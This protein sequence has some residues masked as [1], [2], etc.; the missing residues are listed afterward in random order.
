[1]QAN[2]V[3]QLQ[4][5]IEGLMEANDLQMPLGD[6]FK[7]VKPATVN[8]GW[9]WVNG[10][11]QPF[12]QHTFFLQPR[13]EGRL[14]I[15][16]A[17]LFYKGR[18]YTGNSLTILVLPPKAANADNTTQV[19]LVK[20]LALGENAQQKIRENLF[21]E[22]VIDKQEVTVGEPLMASFQLHTRLLSDAKI[23]RRPSFNGF[24]VVDMEA[25]ET[26]KF[27][28]TQH[29]GK[30]YNT[31]VIRKVQ[32]FPLLPGTLE[33]EPLEVMNTVRFYRSRHQI[34]NKSRAPSQWMENVQAQMEA[35]A[36]FE[37]ETYTT[38][39]QTLPLKV[40]VKPLP[41]DQ[42]PAD[43]EGAVGQFNIEAKLLP[44]TISL[45]ETA[46]LRITISGS[47]NFPLLAPP[48]LAL[49]SGLEA[50]APKVSEQLQ[51][52][53][54]PLSGW[55]QFDYPV[56]AHKAGVHNLPSLRFSYYDMQARRYKT[57]VTQPLQL[58][59]TPPVKTKEADTPSTTLPAA[60][61]WLIMLAVLMIVFVGWWTWQMRKP[62]EKDS[63]MMLT[64]EP[65][66]SD[67][68]PP[69]PVDTLLTKAEEALQHGR[70][71]QF[72]ACIMDAWFLFFEERLGIPAAERSVK[73]IVNH[74]R[75]HPTLQTHALALEK[76]FNT[77]E[78]QL[79]APGIEV[80]HRATFLKETASLMRAFDVQL[81]INGVG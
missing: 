69:T 14:Y 42:Q 38:R 43:F 52:S 53:Q 41:T 2:E 49:P 4:W 56:V 20:E 40:K 35:A 7:E 9:T 81:Q 70:G 36:A 77:C 60:A 25:P 6:G 21:L 47:G 54:Y 50:F 5:M 18:K 13:Q 28:P 22:G 26:G 33:I 59:V 68:K 3:L 45:T 32:L 17:I 10:S 44:R 12:V 73:R 15:P 34:S 37:K 57:V 51:T 39:L 78:R 19:P 29:K 48:A 46:V 72:F 67:P 24:S 1:M 66:A 55:R 62:M 31:Y 61:P 74:L 58:K 16:P 65:K 63:T 80:L 76:I 23:E 64:V 11:L 30:W 8:K 71:K 79:F 75:E 27:V